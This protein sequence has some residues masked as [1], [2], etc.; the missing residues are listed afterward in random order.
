MTKAERILWKRLRADDLPDLHFRRQSPIGP[1]FPDFVS[2]S[3]KLIVEVDGGIHTRDDV[4]SRDAEREAF[5]RGRSY[6]I[7]RFSNRE[8]EADVGRVARLI[9]CA[10]ADTPTPGPSPQGGGEGA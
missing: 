3:V 7:L 8:I 9:V 4:A 10:A 1:Y 5:L 6:R 2:H